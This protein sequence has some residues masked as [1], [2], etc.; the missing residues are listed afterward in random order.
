[1]EE[2]DQTYQ[3]LHLTALQDMHLLHAASRY[4]H[5]ETFRGL[6]FFFLSH[7][8]WT[9]AR[10]LA[11]QIRAVTYPYPAPWDGRQSL[12]ALIAEMRRHK[13][14]A[15]IGVHVR[16]SSHLFEYYDTFHYPRGWQRLCDSSAPVDP[17]TAGRADDF[18]Y[19]S[20]L[21]SVLLCFEGMLHRLRPGRNTTAPDGSTAAPPR[22]PPPQAAAPPTP[23]EA[24]VIVLWAT[25]DDALSRPLL[26]AITS[27]PGVRAVRIAFDAPLRADAHAQ[28]ALLDLQLLAEADELLATAM[29]TFSFA[30]HA[31][32]LVTPHYL[33]FRDPCGPLGACSRAAGPEAGLLSFGVAHDGCRLADG[34]MLCARTVDAC[35]APLLDP[36]WADGETIGCIGGGGGDWCAGGGGGPGEGR[37]AGPPPFAARYLGG[38]D[39]AR[40]FEHLWAKR[41]MRVQAEDPAL[42]LPPCP[43][44][45][46]QGREILRRAATAP[47][48]GGGVG[49]AWRLQ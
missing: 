23:I 8:L 21:D 31:R 36:G 26:D 32:G 4:K 12:H 15:L 48:P 1:M 35:L 13:P 46:E 49:A 14:L 38:M 3:I 9:G 16:V 7:F 39:H 10:E 47:P 37:R 17:S 20:S 40:Q 34:G 42:A 33:S 25:D 41:E 29:S 45:R 27:L 44:K 18:C 43:P 5:R 11:T 22:H 24:S 28:T 19:S 2:I 30:A 6:E